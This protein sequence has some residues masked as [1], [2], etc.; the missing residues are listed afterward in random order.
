MANYDAWNNLSAAEK[1]TV[2]DTSVVHVISGAKHSSSTITYSFWSQ[3]YDRIDPSSVPTGEV[4]VFERFSAYERGFTRLILDYLEGFLDVDFVETT[5]TS[6]TLGFGKHNMI[7]GGYAT[8]PYGGQQEVYIDSGKSN[9]RIGDFGL[10]TIVHELGHALGL[11][12]PNDYI[13]GAAER[14][15]RDL[16]TTM[17]SIM[18]YN[19]AWYSD[20]LT[21]PDVD[22]YFTFFGLLDIEA[23]LKIYGAKP[24][25]ENNTYKLNLKGDAG[26]SGTVWDV[27]I[28]IPFVLADNAGYDIVDAST[29][30]LP[31]QLSSVLFDFSQG[32]SLGLGQT[33]DVYSNSLEEWIAL[34]TSDKVPHLQI[35]HDTTIEEFVGTLFAETVLGNGAGQTVRA[36]AGND[37]IMGAG[38]SDVIDGGTGE[39][40]AKYAGERSQFSLSLTKSGVT[41]IA[42]RQ[43]VEGTDF[44]SNVENIDFASGKDIN[45]DQLDGVVNVAPA[46]L[47][48]FIEMYIAYFN[49]APDAEGLFYWG[50]RLNDGMELSQI[51]KSFFVQPETVALYPDPNDTTG[52]VTSV[53]NN[54][55]GRAPDTAGF[56]YWVDELNSGSV[57]RD[58]FMLAIINGAKA[59]TGNPADVDYITGKANIGA[60]FSVI[61]GMSE[62][63]N[64]KAA[65]ALY[66]GSDAGLAAAKNAVDGYYASAL[67]A[68]NG[69]FLINLVG[70]MDD[71]FAV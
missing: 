67:N 71:P 37:I 10:G 28:A 58:I 23:L 46:D 43:G 5:E 12:H 25:F 6:A 7:P 8:Y 2:L 40:T 57:S 50:T 27:P 14:L 38:G 29:L 44:V 1:L 59:A 30:Q 13:T 65:M 51:A 53:Y 22:N 48:V 35:H 24:T 63:S 9:G 42:D 31:G 70:V 69:E 47:T 19:S 55:L 11:S 18:S 62:V 56:N 61:K 17:L 60:Y 64:A 21:D 3:D 52:F 33:L 36:G 49:R 32:L 68:N 26:K 39:D 41:S 16:D 4:A 15:D 66:D 45:L 54:F 20:A 34:T